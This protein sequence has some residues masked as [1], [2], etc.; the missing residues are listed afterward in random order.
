M[1][2]QQQQS[3]KSNQILTVTNRS[4]I[5]Y[6]YIF[7]DI[8]RSDLSSK[9]VSAEQLSV[10]ALILLRQHSDLHWLTTEGKKRHPAAVKAKKV[11]I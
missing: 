3:F 7:Y 10:V 5:W 2:P 6:N 4:G 9:P 8:A 11:V 1:I